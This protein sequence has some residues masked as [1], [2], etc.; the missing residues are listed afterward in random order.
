MVSAT[1]VAVV[2]ISGLLVLVGGAGIARVHNADK[3]VKAAVPV[4]QAQPEQPAKPSA[5]KAAAED[6]AYV[7]GFTMKDIDGKDQELAQ[8]KGKVVL[9]VNVASQCGLTPQ[10]EELQ[11][12]YAAKK[13]AGLVVLGFPANNFGSQEPGSNADIKQ[14]CASKYSVTFPLFEKISVKGDDTHPLY[15]KLAEQPRPVGGEPAWNFTKFLVDKSGK[16]VARF[17]PKVKPDAK[18]LTSKIDELLAAK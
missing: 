5:P 6:P 1:T 17:E 11:K 15:K 2:S 14:F 16:V 13:D 9:V 7:L 3:Q 10:Y 8:Y 12:L 18:D 4:V